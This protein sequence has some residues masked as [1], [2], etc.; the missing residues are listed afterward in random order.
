MC[1]EC[2]RRDEGSCTY[3]QH[4]RTQLI[5]EQT[6]LIDNLTTELYWVKHNYDQ[7]WGLLFLMRTGSQD[8]AEALLKRLRSGEEISGI[9]AT[10]APQPGS[11][12]GQTVSE[13][14][15]QTD[16]DAML[17]DQL[18]MGSGPGT[19]QSLFSPA[20]A[21]LQG[22]L[23]GLEESIELMITEYEASDEAALDGGTA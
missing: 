14:Q 16:F 4:A 22:L 7:L 20:L 2:Q 9:L 15:T 8:E 6:L 18:S 11:G 5:S 21:S 1:T 13:L 12:S 10:T 3:E 19:E 23:P 17:R